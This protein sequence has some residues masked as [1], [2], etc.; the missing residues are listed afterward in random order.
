M[1]ARLLTRGDDFG[2]F[3]TANLAIKDCID[4]GILKNV[5]IMMIT[6]FWEDAIEMFKG[7]DDI[8]LG[9][10]LSINAEWLDI[11]WQP[12]LPPEKVPSLI[13]ENGCLRQ[14]I[15]EQSEANL[16]EIL[17]ECQAQLDLARSKGLNIEYA[18]THCCFDWFHD[19]KAGEMLKEWAHKE[20]LVYKGDYKEFSRMEKFEMHNIDSYVNSLSQL[21]ANKNYIMVAHPCYPVAELANVG[22]APGDIGKVGADRDFQRQMFMHPNVLDTIQS[23]NIELIKYTEI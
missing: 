23:S 15:Q 22:Q 5:S 17:A 14:K 16:D 10:H 18:D 3:K 4:Q 9:A 1:K 7:R 6:D 11:D 13:S 2:S 20:G 21:E 19:G 12:V 8:C